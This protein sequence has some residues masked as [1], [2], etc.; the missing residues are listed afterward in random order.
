MTGLDTVQIR[1][2]VN[3]EIIGERASAPIP[4]L[5]PLLFPEAHSLFVGIAASGK[6]KSRYD[7]RD[8]KYQFAYLEG[9]L[10]TVSPTIATTYWRDHGLSP[11]EA[12]QASISGKPTRPERPL[13]AQELDIKHD[14]EVFDQDPL[15][16][17]QLIKAIEPW[18]NPI[19]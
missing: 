13:G 2:R 17:T 14:K 6:F 9:H 10:L 8:T 11:E 19:T 4:F 16:D 18:K 15:Y 1:Y 5:F 3:V 12:K 7:R